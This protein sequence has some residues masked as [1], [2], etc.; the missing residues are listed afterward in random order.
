MMNSKEVVNRALRRQ[1][2]DRMPVNAEFTPEIRDRLMAHVGASDYYD[3]CTK[4][5]SDMLI[6]GGGIGNSYYMN[7]PSK[8]DY[9]CP[10]GCTW[11]W[12][13]NESGA[14]TEM[15][16]RPL[17]DDEDGD[18]LDAYQIPDPEDPATFEALDNLIK[19]YG[20]DY[21]ICFA[22]TC[23][24]FEASW[25]TH[26][27]E[28]TLMDMLANEE[29]ANKL[30]DK[31]M[32]FPLR[33]GLKALDYP[34]DMIW[35]GD[36]MGLQ[37]NMLMSADL[38][39]KYF[40]PRMAKLISAYKEK[41]PNI[42][43]AYHSCGNIEPIIEDFIEIGLDVLNPIQPKAMDP[44]KLKEKYGDRLS[45]WGGMC[46]QETLPYGTPEDV[47]AEVLL[48]KNTIGKNGGYLCAPAHNVQSDTS[49]ENMLAFFEAAKEY[50][51]Y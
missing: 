14:Y 36:D 8:D 9:V 4:L 31:M 42:L 2:P 3:L 10:W 46:I 41:N 21:F 18:K 32:E 16:E 37:N 45:F 39:R 13:E 48:R 44:A 6:L 20:N 28:D 49:V 33:A 5:G 50:G 40:K 24:I 27:M 17:A 38:W 34:I 35:L 30:F 47:K 15:V 11:R 7:Y 51:K 43:V 22:S 23:S 26:G 1:N 12:F 29:Y 25:Y 19:K